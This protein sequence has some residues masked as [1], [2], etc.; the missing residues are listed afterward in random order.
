MKGHRLGVCGGGRSEVEIREL[1]RASPRNPLDHSRHLCP[2]PIPCQI[3]P[4]SRHI[5]PQELRQARIQGVRPVCRIS[6]FSI[7]TTC[8]V[9]NSPLHSYGMTLVYSHLSTSL[10]LTKSSRISRVLNI[11]N[12]GYLLGGVR[13]RAAWLL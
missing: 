5:R 6:G 10:L 7:T 13:N 4:S 9:S 1:P 2:L 12:K 11:T 8:L 3:H